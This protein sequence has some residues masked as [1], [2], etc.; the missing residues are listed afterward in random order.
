MLFAHRQLDEF[1]DS[2]EWMFRSV[3]R[4]PNF[5]NSQMPVTSHP[6]KL[7]FN[8]IVRQDKN[9]VAVRVTE[10]YD[11]KAIRSWKLRSPHLTSIF[12]TSREYRTPYAMHP[13]VRPR[14]RDKVSLLFALS[15][16]HVLHTFLHIFSALRDE[17]YIFALY[18]I[19]R[20]AEDI[21][22]HLGYSFVCLW[23]N[24]VRDNW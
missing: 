4:R 2:N 12:K 21:A 23:E 10:K 5:P 22:A 9:G 8:G 13:V 14:K 7:Q 1:V 17:Q 19:E 20:T 24:F 18:D 11:Y 3:I 15:F 6:I 16:P